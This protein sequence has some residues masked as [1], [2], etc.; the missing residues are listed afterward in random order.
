MHLLTEINGSLAKSGSASLSGV[1]APA[2][3]FIASGLDRPGSV[4]VITPDEVSARDFVRDLT[5]F[6]GYSEALYFP[7]AVFSSAVF[8]ANR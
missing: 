5:L 1:T 7:P 8:S 3:A 2:A 4:V 6:M